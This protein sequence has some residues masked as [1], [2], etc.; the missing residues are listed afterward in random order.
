[1]SRLRASVTAGA[2]GKSRDGDRFRGS[3][4]QRGTRAGDRQR[5]ERTR[6]SLREAPPETR[7]EEDEPPGASGADAQRDARRP[8]P[9]SPTPPRRRS[10]EDPPRR[11]PQRLV[12]SP[13]SPSGNRRVS[14]RDR[15]PSASGQ[16][17]TSPAAG[18]AA[19]H[20]GWSPRA[21]HR[22]SALRGSGGAS[23]PTLTPNSESRRA[24]GDDDH[25]VVTRDCNRQ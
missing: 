2:T 24:G 3:R 4:G 11:V 8:P 21:R 13:R 20:R 16:R 6:E 1:M 10:G 17:A 25:Q 5:E 19:G 7:S 9:R 14:W 23:R 15:S 12:I 18:Q 22:P